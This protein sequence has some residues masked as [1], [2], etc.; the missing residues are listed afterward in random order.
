MIS[1]GEKDLYILIVARG[2]PSKKY[3]VNG[4]FEFDQAKALADQGHK[5]V[6][7]AL[8]MRSIRRSRNWGIKEFQKNG[9]NIIEINFPASGLPDTLFN[10]IGKRLILYVYNRILKK[11]G[12]PDILHAHFWDVAIMATDLCEKEGVPFVITEHSSLMNVDNLDKK[13]ATKAISVYKKAEQVIAVSR[14][15]EGKIKKNTG[16]QCKVVHNIVDIDDFLYEK[17]KK[18]EEG[19]KFVSTGNLKTSKGFDILINAFKK[20]CDEFP[21]CSLS[22]IGGGEEE[23]NLN[24]LVNKLNLMEQV[25]FKGQL[26]RND[27]AKIYNEADAFVLSSR[28]ETFGVVYIE[29]MS[30]GLPII[31]TKCGGPEDF[32]NPNVGI[33][34]E[35]DNVEEL[36]G[37]MKFMVTS[38]DRFNN[39]LIS[40]FAK[41]SF[42]PEVISKQLTM[43]YRDILFDRKTDKEQ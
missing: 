2:V 36:Y 39:E 28:S 6:Y 16:I 1:S 34:V 4:I 13:T 32:I 29:A 41:M 25:K 40:S 24:L 23:E 8:D 15:L 38:K 10:E 11:Y 22:I 30:S 18:T 31:A 7:I 17:S 14:A 27:I 37:A 21:W 5:V 35:T 33:L 42:S 26:E 20:V 43:I 19:F 3:P 12:K 9:V